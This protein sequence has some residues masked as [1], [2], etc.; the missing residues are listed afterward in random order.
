MI[1][2]LLI[3]I[4]LFMLCACEEQ[5]LDPQ[6]TTTD[7]STICEG[8][9]E[10][11][12]NETEDD[13]ATTITLQGHVSLGTP[14]R[15]AKVK[16]YAVYTD[17]ADRENIEQSKNLIGEGTT[18]D[19][20]Y[21]NKN[22]SWDES[23]QPYQDYLPNEIGNADENGTFQITITKPDISEQGVWHLFVISGGCYNEFS[24]AD[25]EEV[26][27]SDTDKLYLYSGYWGEATAN[28]IYYIDGFST[29]FWQFA[30][31]KIQEG[32]YY[33][34]AWRDQ[35]IEWSLIFG[36]S[37][38]NHETTAEKVY[39]DKLAALWSLGASYL[40]S[41]HSLN[42]LELWHKYAQD[43][44]DG[45]IDGIDGQG[46]DVPLT[47]DIPLQAKHFL[48]DIPQQLIEFCMQNY[49]NGMKKRGICS[50]LTGGLFINNDH[51]VGYYGYSMVMAHIYHFA[52]IVT[53]TNNSRVFPTLLEDIQLDAEPPVISF[54]NYTGTADSLASLSDTVVFHVSATDN[55]SEVAWLEA[56]ILSERPYVYS[57]HNP[58][59]GLFLRNSDYGV[60]P[61]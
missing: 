10:E 54:H 51:A 9:C 34:H 26:C 21:V 14:L 17:S 12:D 48:L 44:Q 5:L 22:Y 35:L 4:V 41:K 20:T 6:D 37:S 45:D 39:R 46:H 56:Y 23:Y 2:K 24:S 19:Y 7:T 3:F 11:L 8:E 18:L 55:L 28:I 40:A 49:E 25:L 33:G 1:N 52:Y 27:L 16:V 58:G 13:I 32:T 36:N 57:S 60:R 31:A 43:M 47:D 42:S 50:D 30:K 29:M 59:N 53:N 61:F 38:I 15:G